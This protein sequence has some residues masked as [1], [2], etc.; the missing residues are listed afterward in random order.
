M[1]NEQKKEAES[2]NDN[3]LDTNLWDSVIIGTKYAEHRRDFLDTLVKSMQTFNGCLGQI[4]M[5]KHRVTLATQ[6][7]R[8][9]N[10]APY[11]G[12]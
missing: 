7:V 9:V 12:G 2:I 8:T 4:D 3:E 5:A 1:T 10:I 11:C 6:E